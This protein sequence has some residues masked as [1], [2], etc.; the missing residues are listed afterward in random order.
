MALLDDISKKAAK[1]TEKTIDKTKEMAGVAELTLRKKNLETDLD[2][3]FAKLG[4]DYYDS[5]TNDET[6]SDEVNQLVIEIAQ[7]KD[8]IAKL[9]IE[10]DKIKNA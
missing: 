5:V 3:V 9:D 8:K 2:E 10:I 1:L 6:I 4:R 7:I